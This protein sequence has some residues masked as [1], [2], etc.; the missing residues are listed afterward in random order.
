[1]N[2]VLGGNQTDDN[3]NCNLVGT[4]GVAV[5]IILII[6]IF[7]AVKG[8]RNMIQRSITSKDRGGS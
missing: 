5:Q 1:M 8:T 3:A 2:A 7:L 4:D 6:L